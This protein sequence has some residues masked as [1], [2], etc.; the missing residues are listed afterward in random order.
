[1]G[2]PLG[3]IEPLPTVERLREM[4]TL[5]PSE[6]VLRWAEK[7]ANAHRASWWNAVFSGKEAGSDYHGGYV[8][9][10]LDRKHYLAHRLIW[11]MVTGC[12]PEQIDHING[13]KS[14]NRIENLRNVSHGVN[15]K[16]K[17]LYKNSTSGIPGVNYH[18]RDDVWNAKVGIYGKQLHLGAFATKAEAIAARIAANVM[19]DFHANHGRAAL[20]QGA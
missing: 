8:R 15:M 14:D 9:V 19:L 16:N 10:T 17:V 7:P 1:M 5:K 12:D 20:A 11:K 2:R 6:G 13:N 18:K 4:L 3:K